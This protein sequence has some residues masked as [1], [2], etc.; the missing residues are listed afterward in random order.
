MIQQTKKKEIT[1]A[2]K[3]YQ[4]GRLSFG[5]AFT[6]AKVSPW[7]FVDL[8]KENKICLNLDE[9]EIEKEF[10]RVAMNSF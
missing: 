2:L 5:Q 10:D 1:K 4:E 6:L 9:E 3:L 8:L 7:R